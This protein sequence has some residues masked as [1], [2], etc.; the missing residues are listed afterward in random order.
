M[1]DSEERE[2]LEWHQKSIDVIIDLLRE[3]DK[4]PAS[5]WEWV[6][7]APPAFYELAR[8]GGDQCASELAE[9][10]GETA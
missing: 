4:T 2:L 9:I 5:F 1:L 6:K 10:L 3:A 7:S 8:K